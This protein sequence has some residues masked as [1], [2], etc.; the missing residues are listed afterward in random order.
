MRIQE[1]IQ[2]S[3][4]TYGIKSIQNE[5]GEVRCSLLQRFA[6]AEKSLVWA[7]G[8]KRTVRRRQEPECISRLKWAAH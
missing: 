2:L 7:E 5:K 3:S 8:T 1:D 6:L 4:S